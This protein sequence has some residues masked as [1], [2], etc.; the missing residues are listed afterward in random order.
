LKSVSVD[1][2]NAVYK[3]ISGIVY[4]KDEAELLIYPA[5]I[6]DTT[7]IVPD[8]VTTIGYG[9]FINCSNLKNIEI[10]D[11]V[12]TI[13]KEAFYN[14][15]NLKTIR[16]PNSVTVIG[17]NTFQYCRGLSA[18]EVGW[19]HPISVSSGIFLASSVA[20]ATLIVPDGTKNA[21][22][23]AN[24]WKDFGLI[25]ER[26]TISNDQISAEKV[27]VTVANGMLLVDSPYTEVVD[28]F[29]VSGFL[30]NSFIKREG[31]ATY[32][33]SNLTRGI[34]FISGAK[35]WSAKI[36]FVP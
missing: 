18:V 4:S 16:I 32:S 30:V 9:A 23:T 3:D 25:A 28:M 2:N 20:N 11:G 13:G 27:N 17:E 34:Y 15:D 19:Q 24:T 14:C 1:I 31:R 10:S 33:L 26:G 12:T 29:S 21:Y 5:G 22:E 6:E 35:G 36:Y 7:F 8:N